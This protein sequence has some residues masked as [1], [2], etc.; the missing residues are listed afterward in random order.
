MPENF[1]KHP[2]QEP[3][4]H[5]VNETSLER[6]RELTDGFNPRGSCNL[7]LTSQIVLE[8]VHTEREVVINRGSCWLAAFLTQGLVIIFLLKLFISLESTP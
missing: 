3:L 2:D 5:L 6:V 4:K 1:L 8:S 7:Q